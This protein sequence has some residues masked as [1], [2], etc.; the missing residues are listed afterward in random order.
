MQVSFISG[1]L[2][3]GN[4]RELTGNLMAYLVGKLDRAPANESLKKDPESSLKL[5]Y[6]SH[7]N[8]RN[9]NPIT[10]REGDVLSKVG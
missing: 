10:G 1:F 2:G 6:R 5:G 4:N 8:T 7:H 9:E 3:T